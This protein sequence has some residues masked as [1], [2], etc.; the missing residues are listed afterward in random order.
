MPLFISTLSLLCL[1]TLLIGFRPLWGSLKGAS[2]IASHSIF[3]LF[4]VAL[5]FAA[6]YIYFGAPGMILLLE[7]PPTP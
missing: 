7:T 4:T 3:L 2:S 6:L 5:P 1:A